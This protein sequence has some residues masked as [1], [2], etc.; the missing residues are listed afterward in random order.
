[1][2]ECSSTGCGQMQYKQ[3]LSLALKNIL[4]DPPVF[5]LFLPR[6]PWGAQVLNHA[7]TEQRTDC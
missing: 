5:F 3:R 4:H 1:M 6:P 7:A 2:T